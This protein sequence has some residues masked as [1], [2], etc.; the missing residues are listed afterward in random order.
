MRSDRFT[1]SQKLECCTN[2]RQ[3]HAIELSKKRATYKT[4]VKGL[5]HSYK[6]GAIKRNY[7]FN[8]TEDQVEEIIL[9]NCYYCDCEPTIT[10]SSK[11]KN[12]TSTPFKH[13][14]ID[15]LDNDK[16]Y[17]IENVVPCCKICNVMKNNLTLSYFYSHISKVQRLVERRTLK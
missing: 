12:R 3:K 15:R 13:N 17:Y 14:G 1:G 8:L 7:E 5:I 4:V 6:A 10:P 9:K 16:G 11:N 2:C